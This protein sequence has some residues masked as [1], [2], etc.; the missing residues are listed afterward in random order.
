LQLIQKQAATADKAAGESSAD[1]GVS[2]EGFS[3]NYRFIITNWGKGDARDVH[4]ELESPPG[5][6]TPLIRG[7]YEEKI[8][9]PLLAPSIQCTLLTAITFS[10][11]TVFDAK[12]S[13]RNLDGSEEDRESQLTLP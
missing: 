11:G 12:W 3:P 9:I 5:R 1:V 6:E 10:S 13:W 4:F 7:D 8:P 2:L